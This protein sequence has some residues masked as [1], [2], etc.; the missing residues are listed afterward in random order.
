MNEKANHIYYPRLATDKN[1]PIV[2]IIAIHA[3]TWKL[4]DLKICVA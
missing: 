3:H 2:V 4:P 1:C